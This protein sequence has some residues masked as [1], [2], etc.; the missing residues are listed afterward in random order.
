MSND[1]SIDPKKLNEMKVKIL[2][3]EQVNLRKR[4][5]STDEMVEYIRKIIVSVAKK[6]F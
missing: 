3:A 2:G 4:E 6:G 5:K 1:K